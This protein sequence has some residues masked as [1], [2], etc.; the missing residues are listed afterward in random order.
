MRT[1]SQFVCQQC[2]YESLRWFGKCPECG[3]WN[4]AVESLVSTGKRRDLPAGKAG[5][6]GERKESVKLVSLASIATKSTSRIST[7]IGEL[8]RVLGGG[9]V[10]G[11]V[12]LI[13]GEPGIGKSTLLLQAADQINKSDTRSK[14]LYV[15]GEESAEQIALRAERLDVKVK[16]S[17]KQE[18]YLLAETDVDEVINQLENLSDKGLLIVDSIQTMATE[19]LTGVSGSV[20]QVREAT[21]RLASISKRLGI[22][23]FIVGHV[24]KE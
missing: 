17:S 4:S 10:P 24:T 16:V 3:S 19:D 11:Q 5:V 9:L 14:V 15:S 13:A 21:Q 6:K 8:D 22:P 23:V 18:I 20:G 2:S 12:V 7:K 1:R